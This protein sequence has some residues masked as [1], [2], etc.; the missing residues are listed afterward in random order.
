MEDAGATEDSHPEIA[1]SV[2]GGAI[3]E[4]LSDAVLLEVEEMLHIG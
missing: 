4:A 2:D 3:R 1:V